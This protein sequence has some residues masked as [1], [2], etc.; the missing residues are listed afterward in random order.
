MATSAPLRAVPWMDGVTFASQDARLAT[1]AAFLSAAGSSG[2]TGIAARPGVRPGVGAPL[3]VQAASGMNITINNGIAFVQ[4]TAALDAG[5]YPVVLDAATTLT[6]TTADPSNPRIDNVCLTL[7]D[8]GDNTSTYVVQ[9][10][11]GI[12]APSPA[13]PSLPGNSLLLA[14]VAVAAG[15]TS[16]T[17]GNI[18]DQR[19][20]T[21]TQG[22]IL[23]CASSAG[24][25]TTGP[26]QQYLHDA[27]THRLR[28]LDGAGGTVPPL[29]APFA[30]ASTQVTAQVTCTSNTVKQLVAQVTVTVDGATKVKIAGS[31]S[32][33]VATTASVGD[34][35][36]VLLY[37]DA[38]KIKQLLVFRAQTA[39][40]NMDGH[41][42]S[43]TE[44]PPAGTHTY[45]L[46]MLNFAAGKSFTM[47][48]DNTGA[49]ID[50]SVE[51]APA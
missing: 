37:R 39:N 3:L 2:S 8:N 23:Y 10:Q 43:T 5:I 20:F 40:I 15:A 4:G 7:T 11:A 31:W 34:E 6:A 24:Y 21:V 48:G 51:P 42:I 14:T 19:Q 16:I 13:A 41:A 44:T 36:M 12:P 28:R 17:A 38:T 27:T 46:Y 45:S 26:E 25:P 29:T 22:G 9:I 47:Y 18:T 32:H 33:L 35:T 30:T 1:V 50:L 49:P